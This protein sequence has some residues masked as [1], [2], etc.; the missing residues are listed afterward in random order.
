MM[1]AA[2]SGGL[3]PPRRSYVQ[4]ERLRSSMTSFTDSS[5]QTSVTG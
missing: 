2:V 3:Y 5:T 1:F 4:T